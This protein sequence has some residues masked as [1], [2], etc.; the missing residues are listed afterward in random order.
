MI[1][2]E[3]IREVIP[4]V[5][6][7][8]LVVRT[9]FVM[10]DREQRSVWLMLAVFAGGSIVIQ[11]WFGAAINHMTGIP[12][13][14]NLVQGLWGILNM[15][16]TL[17]LVV[18]LSARAGVA[19]KARIARIAAAATVSAGMGLCFAITSPALR[20]TPPPTPSAFTAYALLAAVYM[21]STAAA[22][23]WLL[24]RYLPQIKAGTL[25]VA[26][27]LLA[28][29]NATQVPFMAIRT[30]QRLTHYAG[31][32]VLQVAFLL[33][34]ARFI[35]VPLGCI[36]AAVEPVRKTALYCYRRIRL[37]P[38]WRLLRTATPELVLT[39]PVSRWRDLVTVDDA[40]ER[41]HRRVIEI[42]DS[43]SYLHDTWAWPELLDGA[44]AYAE[45]TAPEQRRRLV[46]ISCW[47]EV[48]RRAAR[49]GA[50]K[51]ALDLDKKL[52]PELLADQSTVPAE[53][54]SLLRLWRALRSSQVLSF[55]DGI[56]AIEAPARQGG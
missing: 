47:L 12:Q 55:A 36:I 6:W 22:A 19:R 21:I 2:D 32:D 23:T 37:Y 34:T 43:I 49:D 50:P 8:V 45:N 9:P 51:L 33:N 24:V 30:L 4:P 38:L 48:T 54:R 1:S 15:A 27:L 52:L 20:F 16:V 42:R 53:I 28:V 14:N 44:A 13:L 7:S 11:S 10:R 39:Q 29:G 40:W 31:P 35:L 56:R 3:V 46:A 17:E 5:V 25:Y 18:S 41:A 26:I